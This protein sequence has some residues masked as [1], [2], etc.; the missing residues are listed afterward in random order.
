MNFY[1]H[2]WAV[3]RRLRNQ[4]KSLKLLILENRKQGLSETKLSNE[5]VKTRRILNSAVRHARILGV[6]LDFD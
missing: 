1:E 4:C 2:H 3:I 6:P 5:L